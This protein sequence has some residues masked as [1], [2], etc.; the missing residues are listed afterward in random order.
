MSKEL[1]KKFAAEASGL[2]KGRTIR[3]VRYATDK[4]CAA[5][6]FCEA[7]VVLVLDGGLLLWP[8]S[9][10][11]GNDAGVLATTDEETYMIPKIR[12]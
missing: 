3:K 11:E 10:E 2:L 1:K 7:P 6:D 4:E 9:D 12:I 8:Q 5:L